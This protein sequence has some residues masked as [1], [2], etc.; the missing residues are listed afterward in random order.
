MAADQDEQRDKQ[1]RKDPED[2]VTGDAP[3]TASQKSYLQTL[4]IEAGEEV[5]DNLTKAEASE[6][7]EELQAKTGPVE[8]RR[9]AGSTAFSTSASHPP[10]GHNL[11]SVR[12]TGGVAELLEVPLGNGSAEGCSRIRRPA[13]P[14]FGGRQRLFVRAAP[15]RL[16]E[17]SRGERPD[18]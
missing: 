17:D 13:D 8:P 14:G 18:I 3:M 6:R 4:V 16:K 7:I 12:W 11:P 1:L 10:E 5:E 9:S 2:W 15:T